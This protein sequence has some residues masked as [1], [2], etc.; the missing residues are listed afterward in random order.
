VN[1]YLAP[2]DNAPSA[3]THASRA[4]H[5]VAGWTLG[6]GLVGAPTL[7]LSQLELTY[8]MVP[9]AC[10]SQAHWM[11]HAVAA[12]AFALALFLTGLCLSNWRKTMEREGGRASDSADPPVRDA[13]LA[14]MGAVI[15]G[16]CALAIA[17]QWGTQ[18]VLS[19]CVL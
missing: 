9:W 19:P 3:L 17:A 7:F 4:A 8:A 2:E 13:F 14:L 6:L 15:S 10:A 1:A 16:Y 12:G 18:L 11:L 5:G